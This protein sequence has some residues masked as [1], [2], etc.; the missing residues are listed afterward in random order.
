M[1]KKGFLGPTPSS[2]CKSAVREKGKNIA[3]TC[4]GEECTS[5]LPPDPLKGMSQFLDPLSIELIKSSLGEPSYFD[6]QDFQRSFKQLIDDCKDDFDPL[7]H[8]E[9]LEHR[10]SNFFEGWEK[11]TQNISSKVV[12]EGES[13]RLPSPEVNIET[14]EKIEEP[15]DE[16]VEMARQNIPRRV[17]N[18][19]NSNG[20]KSTRIFGNQSSHKWSRMDFSESNHKKPRKQLFKSDFNLDCGTD[21]TTMDGLPNEIASDDPIIEEDKSPLQSHEFSFS[22]QGVSLGKFGYSPS[23]IVSFTLGGSKRIKAPRSYCD[24]MEVIMASFKVDPSSAFIIG[25]LGEVLAFF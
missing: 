21:K 24:D 18:E 3:I 12:V 23:R 1:L 16:S 17:E 9:S 5:V 25:V 6:S 8:L 10:A 11:H 4:P 22:S 19:E 7:V 15:V 14:Y 2:N 13:S 20:Y